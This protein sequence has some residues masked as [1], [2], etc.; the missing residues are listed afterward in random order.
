M[1]MRRHRFTQTTREGEKQSKHK[2]D[3]SAY[4]GRAV[5]LST[6]RVQE[7]P[8]LFVQFGRHTRDEIR[9]SSL[10]NACFKKQR[11]KEPEA[12]R[13]ISRSQIDNTSGDWKIRS[14]DGRTKSCPTMIIVGSRQARRNTAKDAAIQPLTNPKSVARTVLV[15]WELSIRQPPKLILNVVRMHT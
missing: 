8:R 12:P 13:L 3:K 15:Q 5:K 11:K 1:Q 10:I 7:P 6:S 2:I 9:V 4:I 14:F